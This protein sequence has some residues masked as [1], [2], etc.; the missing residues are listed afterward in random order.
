MKTFRITELGRRFGLA[1]STLLHYDRIGLLRPGARTASDYRVYTEQDLAR[2]ER[3]CLYR[4][5]GLGLSDIACILDRSDDE[6]VVLER[7]LREIGQEA[8]SLRSQQRVLAAMLR[9]AAGGLGPSGLDKELW[10]GLQKACGLDQAALRRWHLEFERRSSQ[11]HHDFLLGLGLSEKEAL[12]VRML[13]KNVE[14]NGE[15]MRYFYELFQD[16]PR[17][18]PGCAEATHKAL[19][20]AKDLPPKPRV[21]DVGCGRGQQTRIL[22]RRLGTTILAIDNHRPVLDHL[23]RDAVHEG[24]DIQTRELSMIDMPFDDGCFDLVWAEGSI[25][26]VGLA[27][28]LE[29][30]R[31]FVAPGGYLAF[32]EMCLFEPDP[33]QELRRWFDEVY[34]DVRGIEEV[35]RLATGSG[36][37]V[38]GSFVLPDSSWWDDYYVPMLARMEELKIQNA[39]VGEAQEVYA[40]CEAEVDM[41]RKY[42]KSYGYAFFVLHKEPVP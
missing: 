29:E 7:R 40:R 6:A 3:I 12:Q 33:P 37:E 38:V 10:L 35:R 28:G 14:E 41:F 30:F 25:F 17:Q 8:A 24:L 11:A 15:A 32:T 2:L 34:P 4:E 36:W 23:D 42:S 39:G 1:R 13:T 31:K 26:I 16:L 9:T 27:H 20:L 22:A 21:L 5:A 19:D 18:G